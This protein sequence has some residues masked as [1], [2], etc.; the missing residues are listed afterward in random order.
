MKKKLLSILL[1]AMVTSTIFVGCGEKPVEK[2]TNTQ[3]E[4]QEEVKEDVDDNEKILSMVE[5]VECSQEFVLED[6]TMKLPETWEKVQDDIFT[7]DELGLAN[8]N[9]LTEECG[10]INLN[11][12]MTLSMKNL[13][14]EYSLEKEDV[15][16]IKTEHNG[17]KTRTIEYEFEVSEGLNAKIRQVCVVHNK[18]AYIFTVGEI[19]GFSQETI[20]GF[21]SAM[22]TMEFN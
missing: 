2:I 6:M 11:T 17:I 21:E 20:D 19:G 10:N 4:V 3:I 1:M 16:D 18:L 13:L 15:V 22:N 7:I 5:K 9:V 14:S 12:Y 8:F